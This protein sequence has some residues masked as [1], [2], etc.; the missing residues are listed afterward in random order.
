MRNSEM[1][2][3]ELNRTDDEKVKQKE[4]LQC[5]IEYLKNRIN[6]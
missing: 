4:L 3:A 1:K 2:N 5:R 6:E